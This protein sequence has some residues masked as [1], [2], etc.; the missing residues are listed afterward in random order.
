MQHQ[1]NKEAE[2]KVM[3]IE[4]LYKQNKDFNEK[5]EECEYM[6][7]V[8]KN[9][10]NFKQL[11]AAHLKRLENEKIRKEKAMKLLGPMAAKIKS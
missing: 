8:H 2:E 11:K 5:D 6:T 9:Q 10:K 3:L 1:I 7:T 4:R